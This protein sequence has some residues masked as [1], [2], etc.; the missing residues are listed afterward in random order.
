MYISNLEYLETLN[1]PQSMLKGR[2]YS[3]VVSFHF[4]QGSLSL[5]LQHGISLPTSITAALSGIK[6]V[7]TNSTPSGLTVS[8][9]GTASNQDAGAA[10][11]SAASLIENNLI[12]SYS[13]SSSSK[14]A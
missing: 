5:G 6:L 4:R 1:Q 2:C 3:H 9:T 7:L 10:L 12:S 13:S 8:L 14:V 11:T